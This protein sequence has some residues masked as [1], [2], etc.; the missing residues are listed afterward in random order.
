MSDHPDEIEELLHAGEE[1]R[2]EATVGDARLVLTSHRL[3]VFREAGDPRFRAVD[4]PNALDVSVETHG[5]GRTLGLAVQ[6][7]LLGVVGVG[8]GLLL[9]D[10]LV[11]TPDIEPPPELGLGGLFE[12]MATILGLVA[13]LDEALLGGG[14][15]ALLVTATLLGWTLL[16]RERYVTVEVSGDDPIELASADPE[17]DRELVARLLDV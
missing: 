10:Q 1:R 9:P 5:G 14:A 15:L 3:L 4:R 17:S 6:T 16:A 11:A 2:E 12:A 13:L 7:G 8:G